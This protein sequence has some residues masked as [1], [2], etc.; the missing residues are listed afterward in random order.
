MSKLDVR[1]LEGIIVYGYSTSVTA[2][3]KDAYPSL[4]KIRRVVL[5]I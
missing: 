3:S 1:N 2:K 5:G 4:I